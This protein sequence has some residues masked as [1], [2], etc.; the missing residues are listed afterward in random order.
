MRAD[1]AETRAH[2]LSKQMVKVLF[3]LLVLLTNVVSPAPGYH[4]TPIEWLETHTNLLPPQLA[5]QEVY[6]SRGTQALHMR[7][8]DIGSWDSLSNYAKIQTERLCDARW[9]DGTWQG[10]EG[11]AQEKLTVQ[12][13][14][15]LCWRLAAAAAGP[16][17][18]HHSRLK[19]G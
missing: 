1:H 3:V 8:E 12:G 17:A 7:T 5:P 2:W 14:A 11:I 10:R 15:C 4:D 16:A 19:K 18:G 9:A 6:D 13:P